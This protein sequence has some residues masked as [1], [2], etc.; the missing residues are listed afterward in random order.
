MHISPSYKLKNVLILGKTGWPTWQ[1]V[2]TGFIGPF[3]TYRHLFTKWADSSKN[4]PSPALLASWLPTSPKPVQP[5][6]C[7]DLSGRQK[8]SGVSLVLQDV[9]TK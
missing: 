9:H 7:T 5:A 2:H 3:T 8:H 4:Q 1:P 6:Q